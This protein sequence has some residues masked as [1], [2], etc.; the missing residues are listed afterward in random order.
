VFSAIAFHCWTVFPDGNAHAAVDIGH[1]SITIASAM[2]SVGMVLLNILHP[3][4]PPVRNQRL[5]W[6]RIL[7][8]H[9]R[10]DKF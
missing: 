9:S 1:V 8:T 6:A 2:E 10:L 7:G 5:R 4:V 3:L